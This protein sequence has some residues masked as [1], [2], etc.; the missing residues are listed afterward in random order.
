MKTRARCPKY[1]EPRQ[2][3]GVPVCINITVA[4]WLATGS[5]FHDG[6]DM[7][8]QGGTPRQNMRDLERAI[9]HHVRRGQ[10]VT[11]SVTRSF[12][13]DAW[14]RSPL[15]L[16]IESRPRMLRIEFGSLGP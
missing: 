13:R 7:W 14:H 4:E 9:R 11:E 10:R 15:R 6:W 16:R 2:I 1:F 12:L 8:S 5:G 3:A